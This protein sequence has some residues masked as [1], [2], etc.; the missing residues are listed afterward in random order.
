MIV[1]SIVAM[2]KNRV[3]GLDNQMMWHIPSEFRHYRD[4]LGDHYFLIGRKNFEGSK[5]KLNKDK[6][7]VLSRNPQYSC[8]ARSF[9]SPEEAIRYAQ[10]KGEGEVFVMGGEEIYRATMPLIDK[11]YLSIVDFEKEGDSY[12]PPHESYNWKQKRHFSV[13]LGEET[14]IAWEFFELEKIKSK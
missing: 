6:A 10:D 3:I 11:L 7:L 9:S 4:L 2:G 8:E 1:S 13:P 12:F 14:P 5:D